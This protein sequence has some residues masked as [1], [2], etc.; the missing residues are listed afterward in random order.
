MYRAARVRGAPQ[1]KA[2]AFD[3]FVKAA[4]QGDADAQARC[5]DML[6][7]GDGVPEDKEAAFAWYQEK[8]PKKGVSTPKTAV[9]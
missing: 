6:L 3:W 8:Q 7:E 4:G 1:D 9:V 5:G 2:A